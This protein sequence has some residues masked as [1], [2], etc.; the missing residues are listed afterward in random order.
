M[1]YLEIQKTDKTARTRVMISPSVQETPLVV[2]LIYRACR[3][4]VTTV[5]R[6]SH[7]M[8]DLVHVELDMRIHLHILVV[9]GVDL[10][11]DVLL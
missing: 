8:F 9:G 1:W 10:I 3:I 4:S 5:L 7:E 2:L 6:Q 11:L